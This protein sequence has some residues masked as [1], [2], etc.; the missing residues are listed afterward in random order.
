MEQCYRSGEKSEDIDCAGLPRQCRIVAVLRYETQR[1][2]SSHEVLA[3]GA[4]R[5]R[6]PATVQ[7]PA[8]PRIWIEVELLTLRP[9]F[10]ASFFSSSQ[11]WTHAPTSPTK[12]V[13]RMSMNW[14]PATSCRVQRLS[15][16]KRARVD[17]PH[18]SGLQ[19]WGRRVPQVLVAN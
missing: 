12:L 6:S 1:F 2:R 3:R 17:G 9:N 8:M 5:T 18:R 15:H 11:L 16:G 4:R 10:L 14:C 19:L 13:G 7:K